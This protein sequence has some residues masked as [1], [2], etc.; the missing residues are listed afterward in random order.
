MEIVRHYFIFYILEST[1]KYIFR[2][3]IKKK[4]HLIKNMIFFLFI[5]VFFILS[6]LIR[7]DIYIIKSSIII[8]YYL[9][10]LLAMNN[11]TYPN[12][13]NIFGKIFYLLTNYH[14]PIVWLINSFSFLEK[15]YHVFPIIIH[16]NHI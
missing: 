3:E 4:S 14:T 11:C 15:N 9:I 10:P 2:N 13:G 6:V 7:Y 16:E 8:N 5:S 1:Y 12:F